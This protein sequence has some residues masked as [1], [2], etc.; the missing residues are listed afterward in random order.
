MK[1]EFDELHPLL[2]KFIVSSPANKIDKALSVDN[3]K[4][5]SFNWWW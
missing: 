3:A 1:M 5:W 4:D 2:Q